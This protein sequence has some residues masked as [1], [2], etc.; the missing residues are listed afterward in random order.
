MPKI[1]IGVM[2]PG[3][4]ATADLQATAYEL[5]QHIAQQG[6]VLL[7]GGRKAGVMDAACRGAKSAE[8][9]TI[10]ILPGDSQAE[11]SAAV[12]IPI[13]TGLGHARNVVNVLSSQVIVA[14]GLGAGTTSEI[15]IAL[16]V[17][18]PVILLQVPPDDCAFFQ[19]LN[20]SL[21]HIAADCPHAIRL[22]HQ[23]L[24]TS[25]PDSQDG[26]TNQYS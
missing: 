4:S 5:G 25:L 7:T 24:A 8:G 3:E 17:H 1:I 10:G 14:C 6:W 26:I 11:M 18:R 13:L 12:D 20:Q 21:V 16:K 9:L 23:L 22:I 2:G 15:A 19:C